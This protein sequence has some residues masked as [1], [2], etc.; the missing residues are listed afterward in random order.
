[1][2]LLRLVAAPRD[3]RMGGLV[4]LLISIL[5][6]DLGLAEILSLLI[7]TPIS[8]ALADRTSRLDILRWCQVFAVAIFAT[9]IICNLF[10]EFSPTL[11]VFIFPARGAINAFYL[12]TALG[13]VLS[14][15]EERQPNYAIGINSVV[16]NASITIGPSLAGVIFYIQMQIWRTD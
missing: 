16:I 15:I 4:K 14:L 11:G 6:R 9:L 13:F 3:A 2:P 8:G 5:S 10:F 12:P 1:M 7:L